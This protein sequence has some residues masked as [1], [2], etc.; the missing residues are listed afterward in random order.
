MSVNACI[1]A[2]ETFGWMFM[3]GLAIAELLLIIRTWAVWGKDRRLTIFLPLFY[4]GLMIPAFINMGQFLESVTF[5][6]PISMISGCVVTGA[7]ER[8]Y[9]NWVLLMILDIG[10]CVLMVL[11]GLRSYMSGG[12]N[13]E[14]VNVVYRDGIIYYLYLVAL[15]IMNV[16]VILRLPRE[17]LALLSSPMRSLH[18]ILACRV[19]LHTRE[20]GN[21]NVVSKDEKNTFTD[22][23]GPIGPMVFA[24]V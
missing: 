7:S 6:Q 9:I 8:L 17:Y 4:L 13:S 12:S 11:R 23:Q 1:A 14:L 22:S 21:K 3:S 15:S 20:F 19:I 10:V 18:S 24:D 5:E 2:N 16:I